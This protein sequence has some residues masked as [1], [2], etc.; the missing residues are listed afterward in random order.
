M[1]S[2]ELNWLNSQINLVSLVT[3]KVW[4]VLTLY[5]SGRILN[6]APDGAVGN[7]AAGSPPFLIPVCFAR[8]QEL[9]QP[10][11]PADLPL[12]EQVVVWQRYL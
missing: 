7:S 2:V 6:L 10:Q 9:L 1:F 4:N 5:S 11:L 3:L 8:A 12:L